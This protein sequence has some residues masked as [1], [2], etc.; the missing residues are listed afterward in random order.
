MILFKLLILNPKFMINKL[1]NK[2][3][4]SLSE[5]TNGLHLLFLDYVFVFTVTTIELRNIAFQ[6][7]GGNNIGD[8]C[9]NWNSLT[10]I[11]D[12]KCIF[13]NAWLLLLARIISVCNVLGIPV[14]RVCIS[15]RCL[16]NRDHSVEPSQT[17]LIIYY[18]IGLLRLRSFHQKAITV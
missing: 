5:I 4:C 15:F 10:A 12:Q 16:K 9:S 1:I 11:L 6:P 17:K 13:S 8:C 3:R 18:K 14:E 7:Y 2:F